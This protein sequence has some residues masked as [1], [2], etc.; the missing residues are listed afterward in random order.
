M[1]INVSGDK[2]DLEWPAGFDP[3]TPTSPVARMAYLSNG[4]FAL[5]RPEK[6]PGTENSYRLTTFTF[7][8]DIA[9]P[10]WKLAELS[11]NEHQIK[12]PTEIFSSISLS[13]GRFAG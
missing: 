3:F 4:E 5:T 8:L 12:L 6:I 10:Q 11:R 13:K 9:G 1:G 2:H 7:R